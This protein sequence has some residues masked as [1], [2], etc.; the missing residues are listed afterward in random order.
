LSS[1]SSAHSANPSAVVLEVTESKGA[2]LDEF[3]LPV[4]AFCYAVRT[5]EAPHAADLDRPS[6]ER[7]TE[8]AAV[9]K[10]TLVELPDGIKLG[11]DIA[12][13]L[14]QVMER[15]AHDVEAVGNHES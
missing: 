5:R 10:P 12:A 14:H 2:A 4:E 3:H 7:T 1:L 13:G 6:R 9:L 8:L 11:T 15:K